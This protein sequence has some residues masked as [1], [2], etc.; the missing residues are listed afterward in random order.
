MRKT[1]TI[2]AI[3]AGLLGA[4]EKKADRREVYSNAVKHEG[5]H[6]GYPVKVLDLGQRQLN[7]YDTATEEFIAAYDRDK[8]SVFDN[9][10]AMYASAG[11]EIR[12][13]ASLDSI[14]AIYNELVIYPKK[15][16]E[17]DARFLFPPDTTLWRLGEAYGLS[18]LD[19]DGNYD[20]IQY[21]GQS[22][23]AY[24]LT[25]DKGLF[26]PDNIHYQLAGKEEFQR[27]LEHIREY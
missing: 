16:K 10:D 14:N 3:L 26:S 13:M 4:C 22:P 2:L 17:W 8:D 18:D 1:I 12:T 7:V 19:H 5:T 21:L 11:N 9:V 6:R 20:A 24:A 25:L 27:D 23:G 15:K